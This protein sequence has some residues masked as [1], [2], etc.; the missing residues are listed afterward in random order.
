MLLSFVHLTLLQ[1]ALSLLIYPINQECLQTNYTLGELSTELLNCR[2]GK[3]AIRLP[4]F[5]YS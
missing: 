3:V 1:G 2:S 4:P 5:S